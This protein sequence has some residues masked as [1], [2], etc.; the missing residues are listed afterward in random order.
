MIIEIS[1]IDTLFFK[2]NRPFNSEDLGFNPVSSIFP[3]YPTSVVG[4]VRAFLAKQMNW[5]GRSNWSDIIVEQL[6]NQEDLGKLQF[7]GPYLY[8]E[9]NETYLFTP[10]R[11]FFGKDGEI[12]RLIPTSNSYLSS[13]SNSNDI[14][15][16][17]LKPEKNIENGKLI[18]DDHLIS[19]KN[20]EEILNRKDISNLKLIPIND[21]SNSL[22]EDET[23][24][25]IKLNTNKSTD[26]NSLFGRTFKRVRDKIKLISIVHGF[27]HEIINQGLIRMGGEGKF[28]EV[29]SNSNMAIDLP[30]ADLIVLPENKIQFCA[31]LITPAYLPNDPEDLKKLLESHFKLENKK[32]FKTV[33]VGNRLLIGGW[34]SITNKSNTMK[35]YYPAGTVFFLECFGEEKNR[36]ESLNGS[37]IGLKQDFG[38]GQI[39]IG[40]W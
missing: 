37:K 35:S 31:I 36:I 27:D 19:L 17:L 3:P 30:K 1:P 34:N 13:L 23:T 12:T 21:S 28:V 4:V 18:G 25:G 16:A 29:N 6:G 24:I 9:K 40:N 5:D 7:S 22:W 14:L 33:S 2:E 15:Y 10:P 32:Q 8:D 26:E 38:F 11:M 39:I 20:F